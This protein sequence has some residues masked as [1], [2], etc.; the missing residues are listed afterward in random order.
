V[1]NK[2]EVAGQ[3]ALGNMLGENITSMLN[4][5]EQEAY[6]C[7]GG[8]KFLKTASESIV[9][10]LLAHVAK[11]REGKGSGLPFPSGGTDL[12][13]LSYVNR[14]ITRAGEAM[15]N[16]SEKCGTDA[17][18]AHGKHKAYE[19][20]LATISK[21]HQVNLASAGH[22]VAL[23]DRRAELMNGTAKGDTPEEQSFLERLRAAEDPMEV[24]GT[25][26]DGRH[27]KNERKLAT[28]ETQRRAGAVA[29]EA[30]SPV[31]TPA[32]VLPTE[33]PVVL[34]TV[35]TSKRGRRKKRTVPTEAAVDGS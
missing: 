26:P 25:G 13:I 3:L 8:Q 21:H 1:A 14:Y 10:N 22:I 20:V 18:V 2:D 4:Q 30:A 34:Q 9:E 35:T 24:D 15:L 17:S 12:E 16:L 29:E 32:D 11:D 31:E 28:L 6:R 7:E 33:A 23:E 5:A 27:T 19:N